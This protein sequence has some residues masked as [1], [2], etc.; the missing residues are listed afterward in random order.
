MR[1]VEIVYA[2]WMWS[3]QVSSDETAAMEYQEE[4]EMEHESGP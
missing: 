3:Y 2:Y 1:L 4:R